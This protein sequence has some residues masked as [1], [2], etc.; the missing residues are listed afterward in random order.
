MDRDR[1][2]LVLA[3]AFG[4]CV[5]TLAQSESL[6]DAL[7]GVLPHSIAP[8]SLFPNRAAAM[9]ARIST[10]IDVVQIEGWA[11]PGDG[12]LGDFAR[13][14]GSTPRLTPPAAPAVRLW[15]FRSADGAW[16]L[17][18]T[19]G[20]VNFQMFGAGGSASADD[21]AAIQAALDYHPTVFASSGHPPVVEML[22]GDHTITRGLKCPHASPCITTRGSDDL[23]HI[24]RGVPFAD[25][26]IEFGTSSGS[27]QRL[28]LEGIY[29][30]V[31]YRGH[32][33][34]GAGKPQA[35]YTDG[36]VIVSMTT[37]MSNNIAL[38]RLRLDQPHELTSGARVFLSQT[39][40][41]AGAGSAY[42]RRAFVANVIDAT[43]L[44]LCNLDGTAF[45]CTG[46]A[47]ILP[48]TAGVT[49]G[50]RCSKVVVDG[51]YPA[52]VTAITRAS[53]CA[54]TFASHRF[55]PG[56]LLVAAG[57]GGMTQ[58]NGTQLAVHTV[59]G[60]VVTLR[61]PAGTPLDSTGFS[62]FT[63][64]GT[65]SV[66]AQGLPSYATATL[67]NLIVNPAPSLTSPPYAHVMAWFPVR[68]RIARIQAFRTQ[69]PI[70]VVGD[71]YCTFDQCTAGGMWDEDR[72]GL[73][74]TL[75]CFYLPMNAA[76]A[77]RTLPTIRNPGG[78]SAGFTSAPHLKR[79]GNAAAVG[80][81]DTGAR[82]GVYCEQ[83]E[84]F[85]YTGGY[86]GAHNRSM[87]RFKAMSILVHV[88]IH[89]C[90]S[91]PSGGYAI[92]FELGTSAAWNVMID[93]V[94][95]NGGDVGDGLLMVED[96]T[97]VL[98]IP[99]VNSLV[100]TDCVGQG[101]LQ[102]PLALLG[103]CG[104]EIGGNL[105]N[106]YNQLGD[107]GGDP[108]LSA[109][110]YVG[111]NSSLVNISGGVYGGGV[112][113]TI[114]PNSCRWGVYAARAGLVTGTNVKAGF[115]GQAGGGAFNSNVSSR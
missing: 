9:A 78:L 90:F 97:G 30:D 58:L 36:A 4:T 95:S 44:F 15:H 77:V 71:S 45:D 99:H 73:Q 10:A 48:G 69:A 64:G 80:I 7:L 83:A 6:L 50:P 106:A 5:P 85:E 91:D 46:V 51:G 55:V 24:T 88:K 32:W 74:E 42:E 93:H 104:A 20:P 19:A 114:G 28:V 40:T 27:C 84:G 65:F 92:H 57:I 82:D 38:C 3:A 89:H 26:T 31:P 35:D 87:L 70:C 61:A 1:R 113:T 94:D 60:N 98:P 96:G 17:R 67:D 52:A 112:N 109:G 14:D 68:G 12:G 2:N 54:V 72:P 107:T 33:V 103:V 86:L 59:A 105:I 100:V 34:S 62:A 63:S 37:V 29:F 111:P 66:V 16:W 21:T 11:Q 81:K 115:L 56:D 25:H 22:P 108:A 18:L 41:A 110:V 8:E 75:A 76:D 102:A 53:P 13:M 43:D 101:Y 79:R 49:T 39:A 23:V 47:S